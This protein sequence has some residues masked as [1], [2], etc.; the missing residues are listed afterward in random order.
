MFLT[1][2]FA[3]LCPKLLH[4]KHFITFLQPSCRCPFSVHLKHLPCFL[5]SCILSIRDGWFYLP[6]GGLNLRCLLQ[7]ICHPSSSIDW[8]V[9]RVLISCTVLPWITF[10]I[11]GYS[12]VNEA[13]FFSATAGMKV[14]VKL[15]FN[16]SWGVFKG[17]WLLLLG[18]R[19]G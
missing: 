10:W 14:L 15:V 18:W 19:V 1:L 3:D 4:L 9:P 11:L 2:H 6:E 13:D 5:R 16:A 7:T 12:F 17:C 8:S